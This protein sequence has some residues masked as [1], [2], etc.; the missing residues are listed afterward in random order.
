MA[1][2]PTIRSRNLKA[3]VYFYT[4]V[5]DFHRAD[6]DELTDPARVVLRRAE[7]AIFLSSHAGDGP[8]GTQCNRDDRGD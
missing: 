6:D 4:G 8:F 1:I 2:V 5:L 7:D 3:S